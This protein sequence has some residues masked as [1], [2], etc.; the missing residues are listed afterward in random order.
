[1]PDARG[2]REQ[3]QMP[4]TRGC[5][6]HAARRRGCRVHE[7][8]FLLQ[9]QSSKSSLMMP[10]GP[11]DVQIFLDVRKPFCTKLLYTSCLMRADAAQA[12]MPGADAARAAVCGTSVS[13]QRYLTVMMPIGVQVFL[14]VRSYSAQSFYTSC[15]T[16]AVA[17][18]AAF[19]GTGVSFAVTILKDN[20]N[21]GST[22]S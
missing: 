13:F 18:R 11:K 8:A 7:Q 22:V 10:K 6:A 20:L 3:A 14:C 17:A 4:R 1:M 2:C 21:R 5:R 12:R 16:R 15:L 19:C 9:L